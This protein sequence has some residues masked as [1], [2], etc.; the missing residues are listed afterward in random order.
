MKWENGKEEFKTSENMKKFFDNLQQLKIFV[1]TKYLATGDETLETIYKELDK[2]FKVKN[3]EKHDP[4]Q[5]IE[6]VSKDRDEIE[7]S[8]KKNIRKI[9]LNSIFEYVEFIQKNKYHVTDDMTFAW[10]DKF[11]EERINYKGEIK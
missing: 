3:N 6:N 7:I 11:I 8:H 4:Y 2:I 1:Y 5:D 10:I 9:I